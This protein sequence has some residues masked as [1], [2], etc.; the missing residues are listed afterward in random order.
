MLNVI[1]YVFI[2][3][4]VIIFILFVSTF[5]ITII[6]IIAAILYCL[7]LLLIP[8]GIATA[9]WGLGKIIVWVNKTSKMENNDQGGN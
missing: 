3:I 9:L 5:V 4:V 6:P 1:K 7:W 8:I 2:G